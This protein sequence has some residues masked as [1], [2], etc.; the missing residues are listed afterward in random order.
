VSRTMG[1]PLQLA[2]VP[3]RAAFRGAAA[4]ALGLRVVVLATPAAPTPAVSPQTAEAWAVDHLSR[5]A[6]VPSP[7]AA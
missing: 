7:A 5:A 4:L 2:Q 6:A 1:F 3:E